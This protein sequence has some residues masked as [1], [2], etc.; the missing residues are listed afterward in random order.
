M[1]KLDKLM[2]KI[3]ILVIS[4]GFLISCRHAENN[5][6]HI[7]NELNSVY[8]GEKNIEMWDKS[9]N[10]NE[11]T[12]TYAYFD[13]LAFDSLNLVN[14]FSFT[15]FKEKVT[16][17][18]DWKNYIKKEKKLLSGEYMISRNGFFKQDEINYYWFEVEKDS[19]SS[20][21]EYATENPL[22]VRIY[23]SSSGKNS[24]CRIISL[25]KDIKIH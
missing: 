14:T 18:F 2:R 20:Y 5:Y 13:T 24:L 16:D 19:I 4:Y 21:I 10:E 1:L 23:S 11:N 15:K 8:F 12:Y 3:L 6:S 17:N 22:I 7:C 9:F 25:S